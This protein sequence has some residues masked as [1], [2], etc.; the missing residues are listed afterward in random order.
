M[1]MN[2]YHATGGSS[3]IDMDCLIS[4][5]HVLRAQLLRTH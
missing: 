3:G 4:S 2:G 5:I 1:V